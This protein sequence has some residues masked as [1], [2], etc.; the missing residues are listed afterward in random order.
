MTQEQH[1]APPVIG[2]TQVNRPARHTSTGFAVWLVLRRV[3]N[4]T[5]MSFIAFLMIFPFLWM[6]A[7]TF[8]SPDYLFQLP[9]SIIPDKIYEDGVWFQEGVWSNYTVLFTEFNFARYTYNTF[10]VA[11]MAAIG[12]LLT[13][14]LAGFAFARLEF[15]GKNV[16]F[17]L[18]LATALV[19]IEVTIIPEFLLAL[20]VFD[21]VFEFFGS[22]WIDSFN[23]LIVPS[24]FVGTTGTF[25]LREFFSTIPRDLEES[26]VIDGA[27]VFQIYRHI[28]LPLSV[29]AMTTL[30]L[31]AFITNWNTLLRAIIY[32]N[33][34][35][36]RTL[37]LG[38]TA[39]QGE[40][41]SQWN[42]L[43]SGSVVTILPLV[44]IYILL[45]RY[46]TE[47]IATTGLRG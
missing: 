38:L 27:S 22:Q 4:Y 26:A 14:S 15:R 17:G 7:T 39:F 28:Y 34:P 23:P 46:I 5:L 43:M 18:L 16:W 31:L 35:D 36:L 6:V 21:P 11:T 20:K 12:Q 13:S 37:P 3:L 45:Q 47:G 30:F 29:P 44:I 33:S 1:I 40:Y 25:L 42:L 19:P 8:K 9:P 2:A 41:S 24:F 10:Y 32:I